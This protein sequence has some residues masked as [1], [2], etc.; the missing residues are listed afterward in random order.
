MLPTVEVESQ[1]HR[2]P[3]S[4]PCMSPEK[5]PV[6]CSPARSPDMFS[7]VGQDM[8]YLSAVGSWPGI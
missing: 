1:V 5:S 7:L 8:P 2:M 3:V 4:L 6:W